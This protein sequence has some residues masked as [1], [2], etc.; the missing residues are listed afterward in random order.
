VSLWTRLDLSPGSGVMCTVNDTA[1]RGAAARAR[2]GLEALN[3][4]GCTDVTYEALLAVVTSNAGALTELQATRA[5]M[6]K[7][8]VL[9]DAEALLRAVPLLRSC[10]LSV[11]CFYDKAPRVLRNEPPFG[12]LRN[13][14]L[15]VEMAQGAVNFLNVD[16]PAILEA[17]AASRS[18]RNLRM[19]HASLNNAGAMAALVD[20]V[21]AQ[22]TLG[23]SLYNCVLG[24]ADAPALARLLGGSTLLELHMS[25]CS[26]PS[27]E[28]DDHAATLLSDAMRANSTLTA[29][30]LCNLDLDSRFFYTGKVSITALLLDALAAHARLR[31][32]RLQ[33][34]HN[35]PDEKFVACGSALGA[36]VAADA[37]A[38]TELDVFE[39]GLGDIGMGALMDVLPHNTHLLTL[40][41]SG[42]L[43]S[44]TFLRE[45][46]LPAVRANTSLR[47]LI[48]D[49]SPAEREAMALV[50][51]RTAAGSGAHA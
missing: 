2:G 20:V 37:P 4:S 21:L 5:F 46:L 30:S 48:V 47:S 38:L 22:R 31:S 26:M 32:V 45:R 44:A 51:A 11:D 7:G 17:I 18:L 3:V 23:L 39:S 1:L 9:R 41:C 14:T 43:L 24:R 13:L 29:V 6:E 28:D 36:L 35:A 40:D 50:A 25:C 10:D 19:L 12:A 8:F 33:F 49:D 16:L 34:R 15:S 42:N 27:L